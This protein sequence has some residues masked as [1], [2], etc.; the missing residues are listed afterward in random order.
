MLAI[1]RNS[2][3][4]GKHAL[5]LEDFAVFH[6]CSDRLRSP[7]SLLANQYGSPSRRVRYP[8]R[9]CQNFSLTDIQNYYARSCAFRVSYKPT[10]NAEVSKTR[11]LCMYG[12]NNRSGPRSPK[13]RTLNFNIYGGKVHK[14]C[15]F[16][17]QSHIAR[18]LQNTDIFVRPFKTATWL[19]TY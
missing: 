15:H 6:Q 2:C 4:V 16:R 3:V 5:L 7:F 10:K 9:V 13:R 14:F 12:G 18:A 11:R 8:G 17:C 19:T 1:S